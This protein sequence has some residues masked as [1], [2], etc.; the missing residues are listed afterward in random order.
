MICILGGSFAAISETKNNRMKE[1]RDLRASLLSKSDVINGFKKLT[2][3]ILFE[4]P[5]NATENDNLNGYSVFA[6]VR[7]YGTQSSI[8]ATEVRYFSSFYNAKFENLKQEQEMSI[9]V[10]PNNGDG[11]YCWIGDREV[12][13][14]RV[15]I[16]L[17]RVDGE[18]A[19]R[20]CDPN[21]Y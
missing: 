12:K 11:K 20:I 4:P 14:L 19:G 5:A 1:I 18:N 3:K 16:G 8:E 13:V 7:G 15:P 21:S 17:K 10:I 2:Q 9:V 6:T